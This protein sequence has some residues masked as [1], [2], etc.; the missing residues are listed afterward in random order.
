[1]EMTIRFDELSKQ[2]TKN[3]IEI[4]ICVKGDTQSLVHILYSGTAIVLCSHLRQ[5]VIKTESIQNF[6]SCRR[7]TPRQSHVAEYRLD[8]LGSL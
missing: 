8:K 5:C 7:D 2:C 6:M 1:M 3:K 4:E